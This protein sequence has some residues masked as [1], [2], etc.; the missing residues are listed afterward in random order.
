[1]NGIAATLTPEAIRRAAQSEN[2]K[3]IYPAGPIPR[4]GRHGRVSEVLPKARREAFSTK[5]KKIPWNLK[6]VGADKV[7]LLGSTR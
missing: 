2:V 5:G 4:G 1:M 3:Y 7:A 6:A